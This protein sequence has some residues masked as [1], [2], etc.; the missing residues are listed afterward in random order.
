[1]KKLKSLILSFVSLIFSVTSYSQIRFESGYFI[2]NS[3]ARINCLILNRDWIY[4]PNF[5]EYKLS[6][7]APRLQKGADEVQEFGIDQEVKYIS[8]RVKIDRSTD[9]LDDNE[10][11][12]SFEPEWKEE[13]LFL[14]VIVE[15][16]ATLYSYQEAGFSRFFFRKAASPIEQLIYK[17]YKKPEEVNFKYNQGYLNQLFVSVNCMHLPISSFNDILYNSKDLS[18]WFRRHNQCMDPNA[19]QTTGPRK[20]KWFS[21]KIL[22]GIDYVS[23]K[24]GQS[25][26]AS[27]SAIDYGQKIGLTYGVELEC[28]LPFNKN[29]WSVFLES[30]TLAYKASGINNSGNDV[31]IEYYTI[32]L[33]T[34]LRYYAFLKNNLKFLLDAG[35]V[36]DI[37]QYKITSAFGAG[38]STSRI[39]LEYR[40]F[41]QKHN[42]HGYFDGSTG[43]SFQNMFLT[44]KLALLKSE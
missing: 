34:G 39:M 28:I 26:I 11:S 2:D 17:R 9:N 30:S 4:N 44:L 12:R 25:L 3:G 19:T 18:N 6:T 21:P 36:K 22:G 14:K 15:G 10:I 8:A 1:M 43:D 20:R 31:S 7:N 41:Y 5:F 24:S 40:F 16:E 23:Y 32:N 13:Q 42:L 37:K 29:K 38:I 27:E 35:F 33:T